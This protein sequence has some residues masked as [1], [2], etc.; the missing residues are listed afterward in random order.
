MLDAKGV[1]EPYGSRGRA[2]AGSPCCSGLIVFAA[3]G[4]V[5]G[6]AYFNGLPGIGGEPPLIRAEAEPYRRAPDERGG[7]EVANANSSI[8]SVWRRRTSRRGSSGCCRRRR[9]RRWKPPEP[10]AEPGPRPSPH[11]RPGAV[12]AADRA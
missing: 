4:A 10:D 1:M 9:R 11:R 12:A 5:V 2:A 3:F 6:Y 7:L 8:V